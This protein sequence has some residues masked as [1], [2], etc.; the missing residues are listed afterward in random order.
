KPRMRI[1][2]GQQVKRGQ[3]LFEDRK[4]P[5]V[6]HTAP[7]AGRV[8]AIHRGAKRA[9]QSVVIDLSDGE[10]RG[11]PG[12]DEF[13][14]FESYSG[15]APEQLSGDQVRALL[16]ESGL[17]TALRQRPFSKVPSPQDTASA[18]FIT[19]TDTNPLAP[20]PEVVLEKQQGD[21]RLGTSVVA[22]LTDGPTF[23]CV[24]EHS[25]IG[26]GLP[27]GVRVERFVGPHPAGTVGL[28]IHTLRPVSRAHSV[29]HLGYQ[30]VAAIGRLF[31]TGRL[32]VSRII[33][34]AGPN[35]GDPRLERSR[36]GACVSEIVAADLAA[37]DG[38][39]IRTISGSVLSGK[40]THGEIFD[41]MGRYDL[42]VSLLEEDRENAFL[43]WLAPGTHLFSVTGIYLSKIFKPKSYRFTT[44]LNGSLRAIVPIGVYERVMPFDILPTFLLRAL[45][46]GDVERAEQLGVLELDEE[47]LSLC[48]FV[49]PGKINYGPLLRKNLETIEKEG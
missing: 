7:A 6:L 2:E 23:V 48:T 28:H 31:R 42:Q 37:E 3:L 16:V 13:A 39:E 29:W 30:D 8:I 45:V 22:K 14:S 17:W 15:A 40:R 21:F 25:E 26:D 38:K 41:F 5:G 11:Q 35:V 47:D 20:L 24:G 32:D 49:C 12:D 36:V 19:A 1:E 4:R 44:N 33:S 34:I 9:L 10:R 46:V 18:L 43:G 27:E